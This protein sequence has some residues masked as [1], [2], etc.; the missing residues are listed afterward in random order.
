MAG[1]SQ[2]G[3]VLST[4]AWSQPSSTELDAEQRELHAEITGGPRASGP[5]HFDLADA[6]GHRRPQ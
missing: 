2:R 3:P 6:D 1:P 5:R 4:T